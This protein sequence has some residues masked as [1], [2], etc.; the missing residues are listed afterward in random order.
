[1]PLSPEFLALAP[2]AATQRQSALPP[3]VVPRLLL[4]AD[5]SRAL[6]VVPG[7]GYQA[8]ELSQD[9]LAQPFYRRARYQQAVLAYH[10]RSWREAQGHFEA[11]TGQGLPA[12][13]RARAYYGQGLNRLYQLRGNSNPTASGQFLRALA[14]LGEA[15]RLDSS[16]RPSL[17]GALP[18]LLSIYRRLPKDDSL[19]AQICD[20]VDRYRVGAC[21]L[22]Q[23][24]EVMPY[25]Q[26][27]AAV[28]QGPRWGY[29]D[30][31]QRLVIP[32]RYLRAGSF[33]SSGRAQVTLTGDS[34]ASSVFREGVIDR[35]GQL[36]YDR[37]DP[38]SEGLIGARSAQT[39]RWGFLNSQTLAEAIAPSYE[40]VEPFYRGYAIVAREGLLGLIDR[41]GELQLSGKV[42]YTQLEVSPDRQQLTLKRYSMRRTEVMTYPG[43]PEV[44]P[45]QPAKE[46]ADEPE[47]A[48]KLKERAEEAPR[49]GILGQPVGGLALAVQ[50]GL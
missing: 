20:L 15:V 48:R 12:Q 18:L 35:Q 25:A 30:S 19:S 31:L 10:R 24:D 11:L 7:W 22:F 46:L 27:L 17:R 23:Y 14:D 2:E 16:L 43:G 44:K 34:M 49:V 8:F 47:V 21:Q 33:R 32:L 6:A 4:S 5:G 3:A 13:E 50:E 9:P 36:I 38:P 45:G 26:G 39:R 40:R 42:D 29:I 28:R 37:L 41:Q 1:L